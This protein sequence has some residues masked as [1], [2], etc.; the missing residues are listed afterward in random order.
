MRE[1]A[2]C[3]FAFEIAPGRQS[4]LQFSFDVRQLNLSAVSAAGGQAAQSEFFARRFACAA[5]QGF[6]VSYNG[7]PVDYVDI[8]SPTPEDFDRAHNALRHAQSACLQAPSAVG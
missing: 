8:V 3:E 1:V 6:C 7:M 5:D 4:I 2:P